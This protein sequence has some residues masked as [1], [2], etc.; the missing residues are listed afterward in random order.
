M[1]WPSSSPSLSLSLSLNPF[2]CLLIFVWLRAYVPCTCRPLNAFS[3]GRG[4]IRNPSYL[5]ADL[6]VASMSATA[7][8]RRARIRSKSFTQHFFTATLLN[9]ST[10]TVRPLHVRR[11]YAH[12]LSLCLL[13][14]SADVRCESESGLRTR[15]LEVLFQTENQISIAP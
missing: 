5:T 8:R 10:L 11:F 9:N 14:T 3:R 12:C 6:P 15:H 4:R 2:H 7:A 13:S 1:S